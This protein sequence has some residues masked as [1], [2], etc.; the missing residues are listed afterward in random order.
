MNL[1][2]KLFLLSA[3]F[4][5]PGAVHA[6]KEPEQQD[7]YGGMSDADSVFNDTNEERIRHG[8]KRVNRR[9]ALDIVAAAYARDMHSRNFFAHKSPEGKSVGDRMKARGVSYR[10]VGEN[11]ARGH[12]SCS[13]VMEGWMT[14]PGHRHNILDSDWTH[15]GSGRS[16]SYWVQLFSRD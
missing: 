12:P 9:P 1:R 13:S 6:D 15:M 16:G 14:S 10:S 7:I 2:S 4:A 11:I 3:L 5:G 8:L